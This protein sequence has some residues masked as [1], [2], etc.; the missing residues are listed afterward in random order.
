MFVICPMLPVPTRPFFSS[1]PCAK[2]VEWQLENLQS[3]LSGRSHRST[4]ALELIQNVGDRLKILLGIPES[5]SV[6]L[7]PGSAT[8]AMEVALWNLL[9][10]RPVDVFWWDVF[11]GLW[12]HDISEELKIPHRLFTDFPPDVFRHYNPIHDLVF[13]WCGTTH[14][15]WVGQ[16]HSW[17][18]TEREGLVMCD[19]TSAV[20]TTPL[21]WESLDVIG[22][23]WQKGLGGEASTGILILSPRAV[24]RLKDYTPPWP[25][26]RLLRLKNEGNLLQGLFSR[27]ESLN[28]LSLLCVQEA[29]YLIDLWE[30]RGGLST[31][32]NKC[33]HNYSLVEAWCQQQEWIEFLVP[34]PDHRAHGPVC[35]KITDSHFQGLS[36]SEQWRFLK[37][38][39]SFLRE[40]KAG[41]DCLNHALCRVP[42]LR[43]WCGPTVEA[44]DISALLPW[45]YQAF[46]YAK[47]T[48]LSSAPPKSVSAIL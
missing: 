45:L 36:T 4:V 35:L 40:N 8:G 9:G 18:P 24:Q 3:F 38:M 37:V 26:P 22:C 1:G 48:Y 14:G 13:T 33:R 19:V 6:G 42:S 28:T 29:S 32:I 17:L 43:I 20:M 11:S 44:S 21:P 12:A 16:D 30:K 25:I 34:D 31:A 2:P 27:G 41:F 10:P 23:S 15:L 39:D 7:V 5:Y 46:C 47:E